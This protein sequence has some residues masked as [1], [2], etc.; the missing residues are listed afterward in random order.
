[1]KLDHRLLR[2]L[3]CLFIVSEEVENI[4]NTEENSF[5]HLNSEEK[6]D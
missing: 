1:M 4:E 6:L 3:L 2:N 5:L